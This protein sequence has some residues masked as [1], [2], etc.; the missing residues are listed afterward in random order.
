MILPAPG[1]SNVLAVLRAFLTSILANGS[2]VFTGTISGT[3]LT[4]ET[5]N[6][7]PPAS[8]P[9]LGIGSRILGANIAPGT[10]ITAL[11]TG[12]GGPGTYT[13]NISQSIPPFVS[14]APALM[15]SGVPVIQ[16][17]INRVPEPKAGD[18]VVMTPLFR[19]RLATNTD[20]YG[21][22][23]FTA[24]IAGTT[25]TVTETI[26]GE[27]E[28]GQTLFGV[29][30]ASGTTIIEPGISL[31]TYIVS[32]AQT[33]A[34][35]KMASGGEF[36]LQPTEVTIQIDVHG[37]NSADNAQIISTL[38]RDEYAFSAFA[39]L[40]PD[41]RPLHADDPKQIPFL[42]GEQQIESRWVVDAR[43]QANV[44]MRAPMQFADQLDAGLIEVDATYPA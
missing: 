1:Q 9:G 2:A 8:L 16:G 33:V 42:N 14:A 3:T 20:T 43:M 7:I 21:D 25:M 4:V 24:S 35:R 15:W 37:P 28:P 36:F 26:L 22:V 32:P 10:F 18:F 17:Q 39:Q 5:A 34:S 11:G 38:F 19:R 31:D 44:L 6:A 40:S 30:V 29:G 41:V 23:C 13:V 12:T 27:I